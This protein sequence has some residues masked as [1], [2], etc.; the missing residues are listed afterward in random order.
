[1]CLISKVTIEILPHESVW[2]EKKKTLILILINNRSNHS[3]NYLSAASCG[4]FHILSL[5]KFKE[6]PC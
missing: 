4:V 1:M 2:F 5:L 3:F 6:K